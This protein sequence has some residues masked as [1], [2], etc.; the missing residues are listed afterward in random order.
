MSRALGI[1]RT[2][3]YNTINSIKATEERDRLVIHKVKQIRKSQPRLGTP[4]L[5]HILKPEF[6]RDNIKCGRDK[7]YEILRN[8]C[9]L[10][11]KKKKF[12]RTTQSNHL[13]NK[14]SNQVKGV[15]LKRPEQ[16]WMSD[17][18][19]IKTKQGNLYLSLITDAYSKKIVGYEISD[20]MKTES[21]KRALDKAMKNR[22]YP[23]RKLIH[24]SDRGLQYC[25]PLYTDTLEKENIKISMTEKYD[26]YENS[27]AERVNGILKQEFGISD[28]RL[29]KDEA[30][31]NI[32]RSIYIYNNERPHLSCEMLTPNEA[33]TRG[34]YVYK[35]W[36]KYAFNEIWN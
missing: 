5:Y 18:T 2:S 1:S 24:H 25:N 17:I 34:K 15:Y 26:P 23:R 20:N 11:P 3:V 16:I 33:H 28:S 29:S 6:E 4:K 22:S 21:T 12:T 32:N 35:K 9:M 8:A 30:R 31:Y 36:G 19:Y 27:I 13:F 10:V 7:L 14:H